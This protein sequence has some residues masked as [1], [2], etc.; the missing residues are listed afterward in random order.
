MFNVHVKPRITLSESGTEIV[1]VCVCICQDQPGKSLANE[2]KCQD[3]HVSRWDMPAWACQVARTTCAWVACANLGM[4]DAKP[5]WHAR[6]QGGQAG[7]Q[8]T[9]ACEMPRWTGEMPSHLGM[10]D[11]KMSF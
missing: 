1:S 10:R 6:C 5:P 9:L 7:C 4:R 3:L 11:A 8:A 2:G